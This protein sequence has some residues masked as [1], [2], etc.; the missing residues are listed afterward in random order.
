MQ[1]VKMLLQLSHFIY[2]CFHQRALIIFV[3]LPDDK[4]GVTSDDELL[5]PKVC[6]DPETGKQSFIFYSVVR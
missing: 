4:L 1:T 5:D 6:R 3:D 2:V